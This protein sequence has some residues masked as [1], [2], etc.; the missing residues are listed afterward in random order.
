MGRH[1]EG[2]LKGRGEGTGGI[3]N[4]K[5]EGSK[6]REKREERNGRRRGQERLK[7][8]QAKDLDSLYNVG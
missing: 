6:K 3:P 5:L 8:E 4:D 7:K 2:G 1:R